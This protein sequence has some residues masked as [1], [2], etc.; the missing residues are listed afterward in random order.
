MP[1][2]SLPGPDAPADARAEGFRL[3]PIAALSTIV[4]VSYGALF[5]GFAVLITD[6]GAGERFSKS[7]LSVAYG[8]AVLAGGLAAIPVGRVADRH[9]VRSI[10]L[11]GSILGA[12]G[13]AGF[14]AASR[15]WHVVVLWWAVLGPAMAMTFYEPAYIAIQ[16]WYRPQDRPR[17]IA[18]LT[19]LAGLSGPVFTAGTG[20]LVGGLGWRATALV[21]AATLASVGVLVGAFL[22]PPRAAPSERASPSAVRGPVASALRSPRFLTFSVAAFLAYGMVEASI[23]HRV[24]RFEE[25]GFSLATVTWWA[26]LSGLLTLPGRFVIPRLAERYRATALLAGVLL[27]MATATA[28]AVG[29][30]AGWQMATYFSLFAVVLG[31]ALPLRAIVMADWYAGPSFGAIIGVQAAAIA[32]SR[33]TG[34][35]LAGVLRDVTSTYRAS[36]LVVAVSLVV[37]AALVVLSGRLAHGAAPVP[38]M[39]EVAPEEPR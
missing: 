26:A 8:G 18:T 34:P 19:L 39:L 14:A 25:S 17:A 32:V 38:A 31:S 33:A 23:V 22:I 7:L 21:L 37:A 4:T 24:A 12:L 27:V 6:A 30:G 13:V 20:A 10:V 5:Y 35:A 16:Q 9:G 1:S 3:R 2:S 28:F 29:G 36:F 11:T 15:P